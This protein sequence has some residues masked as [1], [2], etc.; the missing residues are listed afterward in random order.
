VQMRSTMPLIDAA[1]AAHPS[2]VD[3]PRDIQAVR[4]PLSVC[5]EDTDMAMTTP[6]IRVIREIL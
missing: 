4:V 2:M 5:I 1:F 3:V 6:E